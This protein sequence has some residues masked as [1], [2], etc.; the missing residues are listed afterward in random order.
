MAIESSWNVEVLV[1]K[2]GFFFVLQR[3]SNKTLKKR[4]RSVGA[5]F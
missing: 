3:G 2:S 1:I 4:M 5:G